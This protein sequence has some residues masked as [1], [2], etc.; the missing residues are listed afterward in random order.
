M[1]NL[2]KARQR[3]LQALADFATVVLSNFANLIFFTFINKK[4]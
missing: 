3:V 2:S 4:N 1:Q